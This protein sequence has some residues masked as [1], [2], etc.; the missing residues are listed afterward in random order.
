MSAA[1]DDTRAER[2]WVVVSPSGIDW[3][4]LARD[5]WSAWTIALGWP[6]PAE[7]AERRRQGWY[8]TP[9]RLSWQTPGSA[10]WTGKH[11]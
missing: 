3:C 1:R 8:A 5:E 10:A 9:A 4:G 7:V 2:V 11:E 6:S